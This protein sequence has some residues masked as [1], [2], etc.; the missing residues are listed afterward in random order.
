M[1]SQYS[2]PTYDWEQLM[3]MNRLKAGELIGKTEKEITPAPF[4]VNPFSPHINSSSI[5]FVCTS[6]THKGLNT[7]PR[8]IPSG[9]VFIHAGDISQQSFVQEIDLFCDIVTHLNFTAKF[10]VKGNHDIAI[11]DQG[12]LELVGKQFGH[13]PIPSVNEELRKVKECITILDNEVVTFSGIRILGITDPDYRLDAVTYGP[14]FDSSTSN[15]GQVDIL[16]SHVPPM[17]ILDLDHRG[18]HAGQLA[19]LYKVRTEWKPKVHIFGHMH[20]NY[21]TF[22]DGQTLFINASASMGL[23]NPKNPVIAFD[24]PIP[25][26]I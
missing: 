18:V 26:G 21:G 16:V 22:F 24:Y 2:P 1:K 13:N 15:F 17:G 7:V 3:K 12:Y 25:S 6:D 10:L 9:D 4:I 14:P 23:D 8:G 5:R 20:S 11:H 19:L